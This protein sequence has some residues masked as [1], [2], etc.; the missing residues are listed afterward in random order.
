[1][2]LANSNFGAGY[3]DPAGGPTLGP[4]QWAFT[5]EGKACAY[6]DAAGR[7]IP[8]AINS[9]VAFGVR[10]RQEDG[11]YKFYVVKDGKWAEPGT[12][13]ESIEGSRYADG[14]TKY[15]NMVDGKKVEV[16]INKPH[17]CID[18]SGTIT[19]EGENAGYS[20]GL[21]V[22]LGL[23]VPLGLS[24]YSYKT[25][26][27]LL[28]TGSPL[29]TRAFYPRVFTSIIRESGVEISLPG[30]AHPL[31]RRYP[32]IDPIV[33]DRGKFWQFCGPYLTGVCR[34]GSFI[35]YG[36][37]DGIFAYNSA[38]KELK[39]AYTYPPGLWV[40]HIEYD[41][42]GDSGVGVY[43]KKVD[44]FW[45]KRMSVEVGVIRPAF[46]YD[47]KTKEWEL[48]VLLEPCEEATLSGFDP[49]WSSYRY[50]G[51]ST[52]RK[53]PNGVN[54]RA[55]PYKMDE[56]FDATGEAMSRGV[57]F[58]VS[59][60]T[61]EPEGTMH[62]ESEWHERNAAKIDGGRYPFSVGYESTGRPFQYDL[63][64]KEFSTLNG[65]IQVQAQKL[66]WAPPN[67]ATPP[68]DKRDYKVIDLA[69]WSGDL[70]QGYSRLSST[71]YYSSGPEDGKEFWE[72]WGGSTT[73][74]GAYVAGHHKTT[75]GYLINEAG[76]YATVHTSTSTPGARNGNT[77][78][79]QVN[80]YTAD[81]ETE[82]MYMV[83][84]PVITK[85]SY[86]VSGK[87]DTIEYMAPRE[88]KSSSFNG[89]NHDGGGTTVGESGDPTL[90]YDRMG[91][92]PVRVDKK[93]IFTYHDS[94]MVGYSASMA[95]GGFTDQSINKSE[96]FLHKAPAGYGIQLAK[97]PGFVGFRFSEYAVD[98]NASA[99]R[100][101]WNVGTTENFRGSLWRVELGG[102]YF[103]YTLLGV[104]A[105]L[106]GNN[107]KKLN[108]TFE[109]SAG[110]DDAPKLD[111]SKRFGDSS[112]VDEVCALDI[113]VGYI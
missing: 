62:T 99:C 60:F 108:I 29:E 12:I 40:E 84:F 76:S 48:K 97:R 112:N 85:S 94:T 71:Q 41:N 51:P 26:P 44:N 70:V 28:D 100:P 59:Q 38:T 50:R 2:T 91:K 66:H 15:F 33:G 61:K 96:F 92:V 11:S 65:S 23:P 87:P 58:A 30:G 52:Y 105:G 95:I 104:N 67:G 32:I 43:F 113:I 55:V 3:Q 81:G 17:E 35:Y 16:K 57:Y 18:S 21:M 25:H 27:S 79:F 93:G 73:I 89:S 111:L 103:E 80:L 24:G 20:M 9:E 102:T 22:F 90:S 36:R 83:E 10:A 64:F 107:S 75:G 42:V 6:K 109:G 74:T 39:T 47:K 34:K 106:Y 45:E 82:E 69:V 37:S 46:T 63:R 78:D 54:P 49:S 19:W 101:Q 8:V 110:S 98:Q 4:M 56:V 31:I 77:G 5:K 72:A 88:I 53:Y 86:W 1:M 68:E 14:G 7:L 13:R